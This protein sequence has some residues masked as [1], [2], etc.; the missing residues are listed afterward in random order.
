VI[1][2]SADATISSTLRKKYNKELVQSEKEKIM[3]R[4]AK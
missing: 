3:K 2:L 1:V 4:A